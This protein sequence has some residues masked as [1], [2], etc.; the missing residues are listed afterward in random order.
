MRRRLFLCLSFCAAIPFF[1][2]SVW[3]A[4]HS[5]RFRYGPVYGNMN[6]VVTLWRLMAVVCSPKYVTFENLLNEQ[7]RNSVDELGTTQSP[8]S[9][10]IINFSMF[11]FDFSSSTSS[12]CAA[13]QPDQHLPSA[14]RLIRN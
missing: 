6:D 11:F 9:M 1:L 5:G 3:R 2:F 13:V 14:I 12:G 10:F 4:F 7:C 8:L